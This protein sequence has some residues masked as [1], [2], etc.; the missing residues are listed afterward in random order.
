MKR[1]KIL[2]INDK[3]RKLKL[4]RNIIKIFVVPL[5]HSK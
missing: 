4:K 5:R 2:N 1:I 3:G